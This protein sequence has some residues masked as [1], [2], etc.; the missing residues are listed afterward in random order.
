MYSV[1][2]ALELR[3]VSGNNVMLAD[4][5]R[6]LD[7]YQ[8]EKIQEMRSIRESIRLNPG[9]PS[10]IALRKQ[11]YADIAAGQL[12]VPSL[13]IWGSEDL[14]SPHG[15]AQPWHDM[16]VSHGVQDKLV[17]VEASGHEPD[18]EFPEIFT[19]TVVDYCGQPQ[20]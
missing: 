15:L 3:A 5:Q 7:N 6:I 4:A 20:P 16:L 11:A 17:F 18:Q 14:E 10:F 9:H 2:R 12:K 1:R 13:S 8:R 19:Q